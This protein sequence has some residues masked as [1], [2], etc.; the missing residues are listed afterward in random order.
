M[1]LYSRVSSDENK[2]NLD[3]QMER[4][5]MFAI[6]K[7]YQIVKEVKEIGSGLNDNRQKLNNLFEKELNSFD[8]LLVEHKDRLTRFG[9]NYI[10]IYIVKIT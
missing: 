9:F 5:K 4:L 3:R 6:A 2:D 7:G 10:D 8:I 1:V